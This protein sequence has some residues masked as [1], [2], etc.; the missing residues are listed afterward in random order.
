MRATDEATFR[1]WLDRAVSDRSVLAVSDAHQSD[2]AATSQA[3]AD[4]VRELFDP[5]GSRHPGHS[6]R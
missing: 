4:A 1:R 5:R 6:R 2:I 3:F